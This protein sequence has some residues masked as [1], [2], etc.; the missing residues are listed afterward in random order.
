MKMINVIKWRHDK[1]SIVA[2]VCNQV[3]RIIEG[4]YTCIFYPIINIGSNHFGSSL[5]LHIMNDVSSAILDMDTVSSFTCLFDAFISSDF[6]IVVILIL[7]HSD[8]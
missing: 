5:H 7:L 6:R 2:I 4:S 8:T 1:Y 3:Q